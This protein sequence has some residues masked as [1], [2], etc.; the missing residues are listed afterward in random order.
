M[1]DII[2]DFDISVSWEFNPQSYVI[3]WKNIFKKNNKK[4][5]VTPQSY[6]KDKFS[7]NETKG[8]ESY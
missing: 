4:H 1:F 7:T 2:I 3:T 8:V 6:I 5:E